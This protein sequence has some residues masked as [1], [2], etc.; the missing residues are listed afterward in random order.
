MSD[1][2]GKGESP[3]TPSL[4]ERTRKA[5]RLPGDRYVRIHQSSDFR[6]RGDR[7]V[8]GEDALRPEGPVGR[9][10]EAVRRFLFG[11]RLSMEAEESERLGVFTGLAILM[12]LFASLTTLPASFLLLNY[13]KKKA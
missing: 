8:I 2:E 4:E 13:P 7:Y 6:R 10:Y 5:G 9:A 11:P 3:E 1:D 12:G